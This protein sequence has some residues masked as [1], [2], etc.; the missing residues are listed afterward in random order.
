ME[1]IEEIYQKH[2]QTVYKYLMTLVRNSDIAEELTQETFYQAIKSIHRYDGS[3]KIT[4]WLCAIAKNVFLVYIRKHPKMEDVDVME[5]PLGYFFSGDADDPDYVLITDSEQAERQLGAQYP[6][7]DV[8][9]RSAVM[10]YFDTEE[11]A[12]VNRMWI[13]VRCYNIKNVP[14]YIWVVVVVAVIAAIAVLIRG[15][16]VERSMKRK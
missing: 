15:K 13:E 8:M 12:A 14:A 4:T 3:C 7:D 1:S 2:A 11:N 5:Y 9:N 10:R 16:I 6:S